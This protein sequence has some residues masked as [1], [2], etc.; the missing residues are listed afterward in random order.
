MI[1]D[2]AQDRIKRLLAGGRNLDRGVAGIRPC[3]TNTDLNN[4]KAATAAGD[5]VQDLGEDQ[6]INNMAFNLDRFTK[7][8]RIVW[9]L[10]QPPRCCGLVE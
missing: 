10:R 1:R 6:A 3:L 5:A 9:A 8:A 7:V 2:R 4:S